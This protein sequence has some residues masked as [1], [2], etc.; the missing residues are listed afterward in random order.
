M[1]CKVKITQVFITWVSSMDLFFD[2]KSQILI[3]LTDW[4][5]KKKV[6]SYWLSPSTGNNSLGMH[7]YF[8]YQERLQKSWKV[9]N[10]S[11]SINLL[12]EEMLLFPKLP[13]YMMYHC[14]KS[15]W[16]VNRPQSSVSLKIRVTYISILTNE[17]LGNMHL[18]RFN[19][20][21]MISMFI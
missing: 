7:M 14:I 18:A 13:I 8:K 2:N 21:L 3:G 6:S 4:G 1:F 9:R 11:K 15:Q 10:R 17:N 16:F 19:F 20:I 5:L 12:E